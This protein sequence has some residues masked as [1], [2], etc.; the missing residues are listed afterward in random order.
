MFAPLRVPP[1]LTV[2]VEMSYTFMNETGPLETPAVDIT[3]SFAGRMLENENPVPPPLLCII[4]VCFKV[5]KILSI[6][7]SMGK[8]KHAASW[9]RS[10][11][12]FIRVGELGKN[13]KFVIIFK[14][15]CSVSSVSAPGSNILSAWAMFFATLLKRSPGVSMTLP[16][17]SF[18]RYLFSRTA[19][20]FC[21]IDFFI[22]SIPWLEIFPLVFPQQ[23]QEPC[24]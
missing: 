6:E 3:V 18:L 20:A 22:K 9:P 5:S 11:P 8:T 4:A 23:Q 10:R 2:S 1:C 24:Y 13:Q 14:K 21:E 17:L 16:E 15:F 19:F 7:S 12:A